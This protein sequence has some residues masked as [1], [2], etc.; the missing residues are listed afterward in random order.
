MHE[1]PITQSIVRICTE[2]AEKHNLAK[3]D[4]VKIKVGELSGMVPECIQLYFDIVSKGTKA[5]GA[6]LKIEKIPVTALCLDCGNESIVN[7][8]FDNCPKCNSKNLKIIHGKEF[9]IDSLEVDDGN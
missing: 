3:I 2:E 9:Y 8:Q 5:E 1:L 6:E 4:A 7:S